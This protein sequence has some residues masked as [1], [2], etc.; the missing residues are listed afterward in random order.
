MLSILVVGG[1]P[2]GV[3]FAGELSDFINKDLKKLDNGR[4]S[5]MKYD[6]LAAQRHALPLALF[7][8]SVTIMVT[9]TV[10]AHLLHTAV[11]YPQMWASSSMN[12]S[13]LSAMIC[14]LAMQ[15][16][17][18]GVVAAIQGSHYINGVP[19]GQ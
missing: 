19:W 14:M 13:F 17:L 11:P 16:S 15:S 2:T 10:V 7:I 12:Y 4:A 18:Q 1:G 5:E 3:E 9:I 8:M 6:L